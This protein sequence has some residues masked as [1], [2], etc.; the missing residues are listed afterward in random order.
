MKVGLFFGSFNPIHIGHLILAQYFLEFTDLQ[1]VWLVVSPHN[2]FKKK[3]TLLDDHQRLHLV[4]LAVEDIP[5]LRAS[6][7]EFGLPQPSYTIT[8]LIHLQEKYPTHDFSLLIGQD[9]LEGFQKW[10]N[11]NQ[12]LDLARLLV[13]PREGAELPQW[14]ADHPNVHLEPAP[15]MEISSTFLR[16]ALKKGKDVRSWLPAPV[17][18]EIQKSGLYLR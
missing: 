8:T 16:N 5:G 17:W 1:E 2:P 11:S 13:Y 12:L 6:D 7:V 4:Q 10:R 3:S 15:K 18:E 9:N 14:A